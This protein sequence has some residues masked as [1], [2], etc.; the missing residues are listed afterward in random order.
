[1]KKILV[2]CGGLATLCVLSYPG[3]GWLVEQGVRHQINGIPKQY[4]MKVELT[5][6]QRHWFSSD[7]KILWKW[8][9]PAHLSQNAQGQTITISPQNYEKEFPIHFFHGPLIFNH[10]SVFFGIGHADTHIDW[11]LFNNLPDKKQFSADSVFPRIDVQMALNFLYQ[12][13]WKTSIPPFQLSSL[14]KNDQVKWHGLHLFNKIKGKA[15]SVKGKLESPGWEVISKHSGGY[16][17]IQN[18]WS[19]YYLSHD[20]SGL[21]IGDVK[22]KIQDLK[23]KKPVG[24]AYELSHLSIDSSAN[25]DQDLFSTTIQ[26]KL[27]Q[28]QSNQHYY[29]PLNMD[30]EIS[31]VHALSLSHL[32][33]LLKPEENASPSFRQRN[34]WSVIA[35]VPDLL[36]HGLAVDLKDFHLVTPEGDIDAKAHLGLDPDTAASFLGMQLMQNLSGTL[37]LSFAQPMLA[38]VLM[39]MVKDQIYLQQGITADTIDAAK[40]KEIERAATERVQTK[41]AALVKEGVLLRES[42]NYMMH[43]KLNQ[44]KLLLN[45]KQFDPGWLVV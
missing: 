36:K 9:I 38:N 22:L 40:S 42:S 2:G 3:F 41:F 5:H 31:K 8:Q 18:L 11:P 29:G 44:G 4:G 30:M 1:M 13:V 32:K 45:N 39:R 37:D 33:D 28:W 19:K 23:M 15:E 12:T 16:F 24:L 21:M 7:A 34:I 26:V 35:S 20:A 6:F 17:K 43:F 14:D 10:G 25:V 27:D